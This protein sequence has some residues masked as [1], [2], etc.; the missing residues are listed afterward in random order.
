MNDSNL[1]QYRDGCHCL[2]T[3]LAGY[4]L[5]LFQVLVCLARVDHASTWIHQS[6]SQ[7]CKNPPWNLK[8]GYHDHEKKGRVTSHVPSN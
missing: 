6:H 8:G 4:A 5:R 2:G 1:V 3:R 7:S